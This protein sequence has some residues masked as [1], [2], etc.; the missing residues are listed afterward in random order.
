[1]TKIDPAV[2]RSA[3]ERPL[4]ADERRNAVA[5]ASLLGIEPDEDFQH[6]AD[7]LA[8]LFAYY[9]IDKTRPEDNRWR[10]VLGHIA[11]GPAS[12]AEMIARRGVLPD[13]QAEIITAFLREVECFE[14]PAIGDAVTIT[15]TYQK[16]ADQARGML[17][18]TG[19]RGR[20]YEFPL[21]MFM[22]LLVGY[23][24]IDHDELRRISRPGPFLEAVATALAQAILKTRA[25]ITDRDDLS[26]EHRKAALQKLDAY[27]RLTDDA[28][29][30]RIRAVIAVLRKARA[31]R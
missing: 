10:D 17:D 20:R 25:E 23:A 18:Q 13:W 19:K 1:V 11:E 26:A 29:R 15:K 5:I 7:S 6:E 21:G 8:R 4:T 14:P 12:A 30:K 22:K 31:D 24:I 2:W 16:L 27:G 9:V 28:L 3:Y